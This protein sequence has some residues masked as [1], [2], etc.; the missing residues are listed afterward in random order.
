M[1]GVLLGG[2]GGFILGI[3]FILLAI[4]TCPPGMEPP[5]VIVPIA[6]VVGGVFGYIAD[7]VVKHRKS[8][9]TT[10]TEKNQG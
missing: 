9:E 10:A 3:V 7:I 6:A 8:Y 4:H 2:V 1:K 5:Y